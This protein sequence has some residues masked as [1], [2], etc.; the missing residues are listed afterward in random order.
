MKVECGDNPFAQSDL[1]I[2]QCL[3]RFIENIEAVGGLVVLDNGQF[4]LATDEDWIDLADTYH[5]ACQAI[6]KEP[7]F[8]AIP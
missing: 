7:V 5:A 4:A 8:G 3:K 6:G 2:Q 1:K